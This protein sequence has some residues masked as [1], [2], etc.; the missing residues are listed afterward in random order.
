MKQNK[1][2][3]TKIEPN[4]L[5]PIIPVWMIG[6]IF[7]IWA[8]IVLSKYYSAGFVGI[9]WP[10][11]SSEELFYFKSFLIRFKEHFINIFWAVLIFI[12][13]CGAGTIVLEAILRI[14]F[15]EKENGNNNLKYNISGNEK[16]MF[17]TVLGLGI[18]SLLGFFLGIFGFYFKTVFL[19]I[20]AIF[21]FFGFSAI[22]KNFEMTRKRFL[23]R[24]KLALFLVCVIA[25]F[26]LLGALTPELFYDSQFYQL[27]VL[28]HWLKEH[29]M[30][31]TNFIPASY[32]PFNI[33]MLYLMGLSIN[34]EITAKLI[35]YSCGLLIVYAVYIFSEKYFNRTTAVFS[36][37]IFYSI[38]QVAT[39]S[40]KTA[41]ELGIG[42][43]EFGAVFALVNYIVSKKKQW[44]IISAIFC[45][46]SMGS[47]YTGIVFCYFA[48]IGTLIIQGVMAKENSFKIFKSVF[49][50]SLIA[51]ITCLPWYL[52]NFIYSG[53]PVFPFFWEKIGYEKIHLTKSLF[54][55]PPRPEFNFLN[56]FL[57][58]WPLTMGKLQQET[59]LGPVFLV[60]AVFLFMY[61]KI[62]LEIKILF[63]Y[64][65]ISFIFW[66][67]LGRFYLRY[68][69]P[70][71]PVVSVIFAYYIAN[72]KNAKFAKNGIYVLLI[73]I[74]LGNI[75]F[76]NYLL[77]ATQDPL[78][79]LIGQQSKKEY[80]S[81]QRTSYP[82]PYYQT[83]EYANR[84]LNPK[85][86]LL[87]L[88]ETR[89]LYCERQFITSGAGDFNPMVEWVSQCKNGKDLYDKI[90]SNGITHILLNVPETM[91]LKNYE[92]FYWDAKSFTVFCEFW[93]K[94][95]K[96]IYKDIAD[97]SVPYKEIYSIKKQQPQWWAQYSSNP[98]NY[99]YLYEIMSEKEA[100]KPHSIPQN[101]F[102]EKELYSSN[103]WEILENFILKE[104]K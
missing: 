93:S 16:L 50:F 70:T 72:H 83:L 26:N 62:D 32:F 68:F 23:L 45:G 48:L 35:H 74:T 5:N 14:K 18:F 13:A 41:I 20:T 46:F 34:N 94:Y 44:F 9:F 77:W 85:A 87:F 31:T 91:R 43:F 24:E 75:S 86:K 102:L 103:R 4:E 42:I 21:S 8:W 30:L 52:R 82:C 88:G 95:V 63:G 53:N 92:T 99:V 36:A 58:L 25:F 38:P 55:D 12:S 59:V 101:F 7:S 22:Y 47:K 80:L 73:I 84:K 28:V 17:S 39:V 76:S 33:N 51:M 81:T 40:W 66:V 29:K 3:I 1:T 37:L 65:F 6:V 64:L 90:I 71:L 69:I 78:R 60:F 27:G 54:L 2:N 49:F 56:Y 96:E 19:T 67:L 61:R 97:I 11:N 104:R 89:G 100:S 57:F 15:F 79:Y 10:F 98:N